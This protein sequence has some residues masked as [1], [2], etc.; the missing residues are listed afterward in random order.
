[1]KKIIALVLALALVLVSC[2]V[3]FAATDGSITIENTTDG[4]SYQVYKVFSATYSGDNVSYFYDGS[5]ATF[6]ANLQ[7]E[8]SP[9]TL[10]G[11][12][13]GLYNVLVKEGRTSDVINFIKSNEANLGSAVATQNGNGQELTFTGLD[14]GYYYIKS[15]VG[16]IVT[17]DS[18]L[19]DVTLIDKNQTTTL[20]KQEKIANGTWEYEG[21]HATEDPVPTANVGDVVSYQVVGKITRYIGEDKVTKFTWKDTLSAGLT[22]V[23]DVAITVA[24]AAPVTAATIS[25]NGQVATI[26]LPTV[27]ATGEFLYDSNA[28]YVITYTAVINENAITRD[29]EN[30]TVELKYT[31]DNSNDHDVD[32]DETKVKDYQITL[33]KQDATTKEKLAGPKFRLYD[34]ATDGHEIPVVL[35]SGDGTAES[36]ANNVYRHA[37]E[38]ETG[39]EMVVGTTGIIEIKGLANGSYFFEETEAPKGYNKLTAR[40]SATTI[41]DA[42][43]TIDVDNATGTELPSTGGIGTT[44]FY[45][46]GGL[47]VVGA[48]VILV[49]RRR[50]KE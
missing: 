48:A 38:G 31:D 21:I 7:A 3:A 29:E 12:V 42:D 32:N 13:D 46:L 41:T 22:R 23:E 28:E 24:G 33:T 47:L 45:I 15:E 4:K 27:N 2:A 6:L 49:A 9:F 11:P 44:I 19:K 17:I 20:D 50:V 25:Y 16:A 36:T 39:V 35:V 8:T 5:N 43:A 10:T 40:T 14:Y 26:E 34:A 1:M 18:A 37:K 30:N